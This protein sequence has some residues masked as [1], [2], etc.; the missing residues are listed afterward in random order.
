MIHRLIKGDK[1]LLLHRLFAHKYIALSVKITVMKI[2]RTIK[3]RQ[4]SPN[5]L[6]SYIHRK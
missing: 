5:R 3:S 4:S 2:N 6:L 1:Q